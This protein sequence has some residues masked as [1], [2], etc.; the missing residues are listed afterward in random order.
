MNLTKSKNVLNKPPGNL[1]KETSVTLSGEI[2]FLNKSSK[3][4]LPPLVESYITRNKEIQVDVI[5]FID[6]LFSTPDFNVY[7]LYCINNSGE[8][9]LQFFIDYDLKETTAND[10]N[11]Y[12]ITFT[13]S[14]EGIPAGVKLKDIKTIEAFSWNIDPVTSRGTETTVQSN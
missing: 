11:A 13:V 1:I 10:F 5:V 7:Q 4:P 8:P 6:S 3:T 12:Q 9:K 14:K 2:F